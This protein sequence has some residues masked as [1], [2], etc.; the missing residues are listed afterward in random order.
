MTSGFDQTTLDHYT[1]DGFVDCVR[2][3][4]TEEATEGRR[5]LDGFIRDHNENPQFGDWCYFKSHMI[6]P[7]VANLAMAPGVINAAT[8]ILGPDILLWNSFVPIKAPGSEGHFAWHQDATYWYLTPVEGVVTIWVA[9]SDVSPGNGGMSF[10]PGS[11]LLG[12]L[13]HE[14]TT[15]NKSMLRRGQRVLNDIDEQNAVPSTLEPGDASIHHPLTL[16]GSA[17]NPS[18]QWRMAVS[19]NFVSADAIPNPG[20][21]E[22]ALYIA[23][24]D[25]NTSMERDPMPAEALS[26]EALRAL[27][28]AVSLA[29]ERYS[30]V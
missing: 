22:S 10:M 15:D 17:G 29:A 23:G 4:T 8:R 30:D 5:H 28:Y 26:S 18:D 1:T 20:Y 19:L 2:L 6:L 11:H 16:H 9:L 25:R 7:W 14:M 21:R 12:Q 13:P 3:L 27:D 24:E